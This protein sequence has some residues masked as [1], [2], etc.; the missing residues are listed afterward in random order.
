MSFRSIP[1]AL[2]LLVALMAQF[3][4]AGEHNDEPRILFLHLRINQDGV[5]RVI[6]SKTA[7]GKLKTRLEARGT[8]K[9]ELQAK[10]SISLWS[11]AVQDPRVRHFEIE[12]PPGSGKLERR[13]HTLLDTE[14]MVRVPLHPAAARLMLFEEA[15]PDDDGVV[16]G[17]RKILLAHPLPG[18]AQAP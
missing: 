6:G 14:F 15:S 13:T 5:V 7:P 16:R 12:H 2:C 1:A 17:Q 3:A 4:L 11:G 10:D 8:L 18:V 9:F